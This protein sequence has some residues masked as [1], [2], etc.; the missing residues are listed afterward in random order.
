MSGMSPQLKALRIT[1]VAA[2]V[3]LVVGSLTPRDYLPPHRLQDKLLHYLGYAGISCLAVV[4]IRNPFRRAFVLGVIGLLGVA[5]EFGQTF[6]PG[7]AFEVMDMVANAAGVATGAGFW[8]LCRCWSLL[9][10]GPIADG[11]PPA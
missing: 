7:R 1:L 9:W 8:M 11:S 6:V 2:V 5:L 4:A 3:V 10:T